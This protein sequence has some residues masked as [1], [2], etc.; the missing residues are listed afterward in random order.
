MA[1]QRLP[2]VRAEIDAS[3]QEI[4]AAMFVTASPAPVKAALQMLGHDVGGTRLPIAECDE[5][6]LAAIRAALAK[7]GLLQEVPAT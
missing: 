3:L 6:E 7:H 1:G 5:E 4:Y 2:H